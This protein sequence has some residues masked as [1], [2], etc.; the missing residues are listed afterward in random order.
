M[1]KI[2]QGIFAA[3]L[4]AL[5][6]CSMVGDIDDIKPFYKMETDNVIYNTESAESALRGVYKSWRSFNVSTFRPY[7]SILS[8]FAV[9]KGGGVTGGQEFVTNSVQA[10]NVALVNFYQ[11]TYLTINT[12]NNL[13]MLMERGD[14]KGASDTK[15]KEII[16]ECKM[17][18][19]LAH[20]QILRH[21]GYFFDLS[22]K[23]GIILRKKPFEGTEVAARTNVRES[24]EFILEDIDYAILHAP[25]KS[26]YHFYATS[27]TAK[28]LKAKI[29]LH[30][31]DFKRCEEISQEILN[32]SENW[33]YKLEDSFS[34]IFTNGYESPEALFSTYTEGAMETVQDLI[35]RT[36]FSDYL[37]RMADALQGADTDGNLNTGK[38]YDLRF[39]EM[40][41][42]T[43]AG[44]LGN[45]K[46]PFPSNG[47]GKHNTQMILRLAEIY[48][49]HSEA[50]ARNGNYQAARESFK[51][52]A[53]R[54]GYPAEYVNKIKNDEFLKL[55]FKHKTLELF[56]ENGEDWFDF[57][58][59]YKLKTVDLNEIKSTIKSESQLVL[60]IPQTALAGN[61]L[62][63]QNPL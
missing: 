1:K 59:N 23:Y 53:I 50:A 19:A 5:S 62:L 29:L 55:I 4:L 24:Y 13:I 61:N 31:G 38:G 32:D 26:D 45:G 44:V 30:M 33:G 43:L 28:A 22:S 35:S 21:F 51:K 47:P 57:V 7:M 18:R 2:Y 34:N 37:K 60:P 20:F 41:N 16:A 42:P 48:L 56:S 40:F 39:F 58:R 27:T 49:I 52:T 14:A 15:V 10:N 63:E 11:G 3:G 9:S 54:A 8:G 6:S 25:K 46:Y 12:A 17:Q 36:T